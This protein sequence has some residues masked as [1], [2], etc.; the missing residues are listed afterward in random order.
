MLPFKQRNQV[1]LNPETAKV[2]TLAEYTYRIKI[3]KRTTLDRWQHK[4]THT[5]THIEEKALVNYSDN[6]HK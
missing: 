1:E 5:H 3:P 4:H 6:G 2:T